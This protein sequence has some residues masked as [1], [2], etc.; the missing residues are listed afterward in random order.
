NPKEK[1][2]RIYQEHK[3]HLIVDYME[4]SED[5]KKELIYANGGH[6]CI[7]LSSLFELEKKEISL[8]YHFVKKKMNSN[9]FVWKAE[10]FVF[11][12]FSYL[13]RVS[14]LCYERK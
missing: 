9:L 1:V 12:L 2:G 7:K 13:P 3:K 5:E 6:Y 10:Q 8:P 4:L 14:S 11:D